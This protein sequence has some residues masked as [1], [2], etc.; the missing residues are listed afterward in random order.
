LKEYAAIEPEES[1]TKEMD[2]PEN[3]VRLP[4]A[5]W[6]TS[7]LVALSNVTARYHGGPNVLRDISFVARPGQRVGIVGRMGISASCR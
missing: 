5:H 3:Q 1:E 6:P 7:G 2:G 4:P